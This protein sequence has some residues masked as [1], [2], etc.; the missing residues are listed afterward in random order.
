VVVDHFD[1]VGI[2]I[3]EAK[4]YPPL[5]GDGDGMLTLPTSPQGVKPIAG[6]DSEIIKLCREVNI[7]QPL[8]R[9]PDDI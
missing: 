1:I 2:A 8:R 6:G 4:A 5:V 3:L 7:L 9:P